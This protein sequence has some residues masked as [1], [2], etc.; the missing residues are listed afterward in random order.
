MKFPRR[1]FLHL[2]AGAATLPAV[3]R[4]AVAQAYPTRPITIIVP[5][6][7][8]GSADAV[9]RLVAERMRGPLRQSVII[10][11]V[12]GAGGSIGV[13][14][15]AR[16]RPDGYTLDLPC[17]RCTRSDCCSI[18]KTIEALSNESGQH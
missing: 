13:G 5:V 18:A 14:L 3:S 11:N 12:S 1:Q 2:A 6:L 7:A 4:I 17:D 8:G 16:A 15:A 10:E 9:G